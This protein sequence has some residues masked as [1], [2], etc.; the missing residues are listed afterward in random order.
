MCMR[1]GTPAGAGAGSDTLKL[2]GGPT[3]ARLHR[4]ALLDAPACESD[5]RR[6]YHLISACHTCGRALRA[7]ILFLPQRRGGL[8]CISAWAMPSTR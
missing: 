3:V 4:A 2:E 1:S 7:V 8:F 6:Y 5:C